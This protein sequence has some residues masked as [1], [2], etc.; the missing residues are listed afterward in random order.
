MNQTLICLCTATNMFYSLMTSYMLQQVN[1]NK[2]VWP[3]PAV[4][5][6]YVGKV[7]TFQYS[8]AIKV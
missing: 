3:Q 2:L 1:V 8:I 4:G 5:I 6:T 7:H